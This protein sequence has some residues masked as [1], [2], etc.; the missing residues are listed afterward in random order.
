MPIDRANF[1]LIADAIA[2]L[3]HAELQTIKWDLY[4]VR[5][6]AGGVGPAQAQHVVFHGI[7]SAC[8]YG[9]LVGASAV[10][11][12][13]VE[14]HVLRHY[15]VSSALVS[16]VS[17]LVA[18]LPTRTGRWGWDKFQE[19]WPPVPVVLQLAPGSPNGLIQYSWPC[20]PLFQTSAPVGPRGQHPPHGSNGHESGGGSGFPTWSCFPPW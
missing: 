5:R 16:D 6:L 18:A 14:L 15:T 1:D 2:G 20:P 9:K 7:M 8:N 13:R 17:A 10:S 4:D 11:D 3:T 19:T 12:E